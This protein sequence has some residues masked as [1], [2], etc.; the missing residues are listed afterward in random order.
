[1]C[2]KN[3]NHFGDFERFW[4]HT[5]KQRKVY[6]SYKKLRNILK[7]LMNYFHG[8]VIMS[9]SFV[10]VKQYCLIRRG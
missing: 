1:M 4:K 2:L 9:R 3:W 8:Y 10:S 7:R 5:S 6:N